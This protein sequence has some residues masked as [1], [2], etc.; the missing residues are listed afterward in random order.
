MPAWCSR[1][2]RWTEV[3]WTPRMRAMVVGDSPSSN[4]ATARR[5]RRS[6]S[7]ALPM[8]L[9]ILHS[10]QSV[11]GRSFDHAGLSR[12][13]PPA[14][15]CRGRGSLKKPR[16]QGRIFSGPATSIHVAGSSLAVGVEVGQPDG[17]DRRGV[18][19]RWQI[20]DRQLGELLL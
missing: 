20:E 7:A 5:R 6:N 16:T 10:T 4:S 17:A 14:E 11:A 8:G 2:Q 19:G 15:T 12:L 18:G 1:R 9:V 13:A 3:T